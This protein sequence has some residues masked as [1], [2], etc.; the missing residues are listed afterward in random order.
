MDQS[1]TERRQNLILQKQ[2]MAL[3]ERGYSNKAVSLILNRTNLGVIEHPTIH[4]SFESDC[5][6]TLIL[7][8]DICE[9]LIK[10]VKFEYIG[11]VGLQSAA[12]ALT[13]LLRDRSLSDAEGISELDLVEFLSFIPE[14]KYD[15]IEFTIK[16]LHQLL[17]RI[18]QGD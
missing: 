16:S 18:K 3:Q 1:S 13:L 2:K 8:A 15:C 9:D 7:Y 10:N 12:A 14:N 5:G 6:D 4:M 11:C 17:Q